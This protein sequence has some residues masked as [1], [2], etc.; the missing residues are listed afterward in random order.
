VTFSNRS[1]W[2]IQGEWSNA[3]YNS[4][5]GYPNSSG[6]KGCLDGR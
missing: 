4:G 3:A 6:Q 1:Q 2:K 5:K